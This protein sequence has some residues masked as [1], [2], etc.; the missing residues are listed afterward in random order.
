MK[1]ISRNFAR[2]AGVA[3]LA[4]AALAMSVPAHADDAEITYGSI[5]LKNLEN[6]KETLSADRGYIFLHG[7]VRM[8]G[9]FFKTPNAEDIA[10]YEAEW[11]EELAEAQ[12]KFPRKYEQWQ[13]RRE[14]NARRGDDR[15]KDPPVEPTEENFS[16]GSIELRH[17]IVIGPQ[18]VFDKGK[19]ADGEDYFEYLHAVEPGEYT[20]YG[21]VF[22]AGNAFMGSCY[23]MGSVKFEVKAG[24]ITSIGDMMLER[25][26][27]DDAMRQANA[28]WDEEGGRI[29]EP[30]DYSVP[31]SL[32]ALPVVNAD[33]RAAGK[34]NN[35]FRATVRRLPPMPGVM[36]YERD[37]VIDVKEEMAAIEAAEAEVRA[38]A[39]A[40]RLAEE[41]AAAAAALTASD[42]AETSED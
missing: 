3:T 11:R 15:D 27:G 22:Y 18:F 17:W 42:A 16:I 31:A 36:R 23:C 10:E 26:A 29:P 8:T 14:R 25:W 1:S 21:P 40:A 35:H 12:E 2:F 34:R 33:F 30:I 24:E 41:K 19:R 13:A 5:E 37:T 20:Y 9:M 28:F 6:G 39:E 4:C 32:G 7:P 38:A